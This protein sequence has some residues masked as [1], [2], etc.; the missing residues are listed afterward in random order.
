MNACCTHECE[1]GRACAERAKRDPLPFTTQRFPRTSG[2]AFR[3]DSYVLGWEPHI[4]PSLW[5][6]IRLFFRRHFA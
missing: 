3:D 1:E 5:Q 4:A 2:E 6:R